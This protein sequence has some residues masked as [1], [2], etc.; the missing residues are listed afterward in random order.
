M[1]T[2]G[3]VTDAALVSSLQWRGGSCGVAGGPC[4]A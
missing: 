2:R 1:A 3:T 4:I